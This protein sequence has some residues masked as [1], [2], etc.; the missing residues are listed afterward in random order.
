MN[1][2]A[3]HPVINEISAQLDE[4]TPKARTLGTYIIQNP[5]KVVFMTTKELSEACNI[6]EATVVRPPRGDTPPRGAPL[7]A[8]N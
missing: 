8:L 2:S 6:S 4:L 1:D 3:S 5:S 7:M